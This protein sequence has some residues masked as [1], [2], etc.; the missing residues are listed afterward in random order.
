MRQVLTT[1]LE[2]VSIV[3]VVAGAVGVVV[4]VAHVSLPVAF[5]VGGLEAAVLGLGGLWVSRRVS[6]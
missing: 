4:G 3:A 2:I 5:I 1:V 6:S